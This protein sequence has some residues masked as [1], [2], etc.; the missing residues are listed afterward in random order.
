MA[1]ETVAA[2]HGGR[3]ALADDKVG[4]GQRHAQILLQRLQEKWHVCAREPGRRERRQD[5][6]RPLAA[7]AGQRVSTTASSCWSLGTY[8]PARTAG[9]PHCQCWLPPGW[10]ARGA[11]KRCG[12]PAP[13]PPREPSMVPTPICCGTAVVRK[14][15]QAV[16]RHKVSTFGASLLATR[17]HRAT[18]TL[19]LLQK[20]RDRRAAAAS[21]TAGGAL[22]GTGGTG[23]RTRARCT[24]ASSRE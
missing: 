2:V 14:S 16:R 3:R 1:I 15:R 22:S 4:P 21:R 18:C 8:A 19:K 13:R 17:V 5:L 9:A 23:R 7:K 11:A 20:R 24:A 10:A 12:M 6:D